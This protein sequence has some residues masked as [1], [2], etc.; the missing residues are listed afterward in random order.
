VF[1]T[2]RENMA[3]LGLWCTE[4]ADIQSSW[5]SVMLDLVLH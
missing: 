5:R 2:A 1:R 4:M 3:R